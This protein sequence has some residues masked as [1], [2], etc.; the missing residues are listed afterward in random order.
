M[1]GLIQLVVTNPF[2]VWAAIGALILATEVSTGSG[3]LLWPAA[4][5]AAVAVA[6]LLFPQLGWVGGVGLY[7]GLTIVTSLMARRFWPPRQPG[8]ADDINDNNARLV[9][10]HGKAVADFRDRSGRVFIDGKEWAADLDED[11]ILTSGAP[12]E[13]TGVSGARLRVRPAR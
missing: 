9:G 4:S 12:V 2:W 7:A 11:A 6:A 1:D 5:A 10:H 8:D 13:V 3:W